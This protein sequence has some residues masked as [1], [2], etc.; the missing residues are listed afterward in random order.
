LNR[1]INS[2][3]GKQLNELISSGI[4]KLGSGS[5]GGVPAQTGKGK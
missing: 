4:K 5:A 2:L 3:K 1:V